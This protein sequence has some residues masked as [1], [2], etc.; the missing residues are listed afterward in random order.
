M[1]ERIEYI[2]AD[3]KANQRV[4]DQSTMFMMETINHGGHQ[5]D[6][7]NSKFH[8]HTTNNS[9]ELKQSY[10]SNGKLVEDID[11]Y[12]GNSSPCFEIDITSRP[13][14]SILKH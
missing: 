3:L 13:L 4:V 8:S 6:T 5:N 14:K 1:T 11:L 12:S 7:T 9:D 2:N 10:W